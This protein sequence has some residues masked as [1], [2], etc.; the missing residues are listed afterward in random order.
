M[1]VVEVTVLHQGVARVNGPADD[2]H[3]LPN[4]LSIGFRG[5]SAAAALDALADR[6]A[7]SAGAACHAAGSGGDSG[8]CISGVLRAMAVRALVLFS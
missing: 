4:T 6:L 1:L 3:R 7:A 5:L 8:A 2:A